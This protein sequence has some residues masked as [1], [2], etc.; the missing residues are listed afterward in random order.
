DVRVLG[1]GYNGG[2]TLIEGAV[3]RLNFQ[4]AYVNN[5]TDSV[6]RIGGSDSW[7]FTQG[8]HYLSGAL[9]PDR[10]FL[11][12]RSMTQTVVGSAYITAQG[13]YGIA[14]SGSGTG[15]RLTGP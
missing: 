11:D 12:L 14:I 4:P 7:L 2:T 15:L 3:L 9:P 8:P 5:G 1:G 13:G 6:L 10:P